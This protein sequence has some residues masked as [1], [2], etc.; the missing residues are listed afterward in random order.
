MPT[1]TLTEE[2][3]Q[4]RREADRQRTRE[5]VEALR[6]SDGWQKWLRLRRHFRSYSLTNQLLIA[7]AMPSA[8]RVAGFK[9]WLNL[10]YCVRR[11]E[12][13]VIRIWMPVP[14]GK[15]QLDA[16]RAAGADPNDRPRTRFRLGPV[17][18]RSQVEPWP[19]PAE[20]VPLDPPIT[21]PD[22][23]SLAWALPQLKALAN[24]LGCT[25]VFE[26][27]HTDLGGFFAPSSKMISI[28]S[29]HAVNHQVKTLIH[30]LAHALMHLADPDGPALSYAEE[31]IVVESIAFS[32]VGG[33]GIDTSGY[34]IPYL[35]S[36]SQ[37]DADM[38]IVEACAELIDRHAKRIENAIGD[39]PS[40]T[41]TSETA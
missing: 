20:P 34:S 7:I 40:P 1:S 24:E 37:D 22:G 12:R 36:W 29:T 2:E 32:V 5:A 33:L 21:E 4:A 13:S 16:W 26:N 19:P 9:A 23:D 28:N 8:T 17:W 10:G 39:A 38:E 30:E 35:T 6:V 3:R 25:L 31:E 14:P 18:D 27:H 41:A 15:K 11:G